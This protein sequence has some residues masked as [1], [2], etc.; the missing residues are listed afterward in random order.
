M[1]KRVARI[2]CGLLAV[3]SATASAVTCGGGSAGHITGTTATIV[4]GPREDVTGSATSTVS[5]TSAGRNSNI[6]VSNN[7]VPVAAYQTVDEALA[8]A[9]KIAGFQL[10]PVKNLPAGFAV[11]FLNV[12][13]G[14][15][16]PNSPVKTAPDSLPA[17]VEIGVE[18]GTG[19]LRLAEDD[20]RITEIG[21]AVHIATIPI[22]EVYQSGTGDAQIYTLVTE[23]QTFSVT[24]RGN[25]TTAQALD[26]LNGFQ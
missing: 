11:S 24:A 12:I 1:D 15:A 20:G 21:S 2:A 8:E 19:G 14:Q 5:P 4:A 7:S 25:L 10:L 9:S 23:T 26:I 22:G 3:F 18:S 16:T 6:G 13:A 17:R